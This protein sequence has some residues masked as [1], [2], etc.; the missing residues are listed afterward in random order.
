[1]KPDWK[2]APEWANWMA[3]D[4]DGTWFWFENKPKK[5]SWGFRDS[6]GEYHIAL[7]AVHD[8]KNSLEQ[9]PEV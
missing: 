1:M 8:W 9:K 5:E 7:E 2:D 6:G 3:M 4:D